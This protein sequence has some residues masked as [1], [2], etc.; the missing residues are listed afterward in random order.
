M[1]NNFKSLLLAVAFCLS[2][3]FAVAQ[4]KPTAQPQPREYSAAG[5]V[6]NPSWPPA[7]VRGAHA[8][9][10]CDEPLASE[11]GVEILKKGGNAVDAAAA[12]AFALAVVEPEAGNIGGGGFMLVRMADGRSKFVDYREEAPKRATRNM[13]VGADG[14]IIAGASTTGY[15]SI[16]VPG[17]VAGVALAVKTYGKLSLAEDMAPAIRLAKNGFP[18]GDKLAAGLRQSQDRLGQFPYSKQ[19]FLK[20]GALY[21]AGDIFRQP[22]LAATFE[23][24]AKNGPSEFYHGKTAKDLVA[25]M[26]QNGGLISMDDLSSYQAKLRDPLTGS[27]EARGSKWTIITSPPPSSGGIAILETLNILQPYTLKSWDDPE[28][29]HYVIE[30]MRRAFA[31]RATF[32]GDSD[33]THVPVAGLINQQYAAERR[34]SIDPMKASS[35]KEVGAGNPAPFDNAPGEPAAGPIEKL[36]PEAAAAWMSATAAKSGHTTH[37]SVVDAAGNAVANTYTL[38]DSYGSAVTTSDGFLLNDE[39]DDFT[40]QPGTPNMFDLLQS[41]ANAIA[42]AHRPLSSMVPTIV[43]RDGKLS[44][45]TGSPGGPRIIS[46][47]LLTILNWAWLGMDAQ[48]AINAPRFHQQWMP[49][50]VLLERIFPDAVAKDLEQRGYQI[51]ARR[52]WIGEV[53]AIG[54]DPKTGERLG[55]PDPRRQGA[56]RGY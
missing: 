24:I 46:A 39:M 49:D 54:I 32:L 4:S 30:A 25:Q 45:V 27:Y 28:S 21:S 55:A 41:E 33:F 34:A 37:F 7:A 17:T 48:E 36:S 50:S 5:E 47:T 6:S 8:M 13:Y 16:G 14:K 2:S 11:A 29:V 19:I 52:G 35:S 53:E 26:Q 23:R 9:V 56:A 42:P 10:V 18:L 15:L 22:Q 40:S 12:V 20:G 1:K 43:L 38:N 3:T 44:F 31:D 51:F